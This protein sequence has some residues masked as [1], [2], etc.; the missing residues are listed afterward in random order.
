MVKLEE[1]DFYSNILRSYSN[2]QDKR[3]WGK[4]AGSSIKRLDVG[5]SCLKNMTIGKVKDEQL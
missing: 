5:Y 1:R 3:S 4:S 2:P